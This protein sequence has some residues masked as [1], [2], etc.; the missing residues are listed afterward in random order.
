MSYH[1]S[2]LLQDLQVKFKEKAESQRATEVHL[3]S[4]SRRR[5]D[6]LIQEDVI[7]PAEG[8]IVPGPEGHTG[9]LSYFH[10]HDN[11]DF[12]CFQFAKSETSGQNR[13]N[14]SEWKR[15]RKK[16]GMEEVK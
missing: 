8:L 6:Q 5:E 4:R 9:C 13:N 7:G 10:L 1:F 2:E 12:F 11:Q 3:S 14:K 16:K 15:K